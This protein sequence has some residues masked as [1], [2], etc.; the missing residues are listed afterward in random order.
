MMAINGFSYSR[1]GKNFP[2]TFDM[3]FRYFI[4]NLIFYSHGT[5]YFT[6][7]IHRVYPEYFYIL[8]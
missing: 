8:R 4:D 6:Y 7:Y 5:H 1:N 2:R 3:S